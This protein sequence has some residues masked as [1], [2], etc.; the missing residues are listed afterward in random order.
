MSVCGIHNDDIYMRVYKSIDTIHH[1][2]GDTNCGTTQKT[3]VIVFCGK[4]VLDLLFNILDRDKT[5]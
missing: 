3:A 1:V 5:L 4:R 2:C